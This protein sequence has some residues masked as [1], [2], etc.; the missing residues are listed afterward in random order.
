MIIMLA[1]LIVV[2]EVA[3]RRLRMRVEILDETVQKIAQ[4]VDVDL[5]KLKSEVEILNKT[6]KEPAF[7]EI[8]E[9][10]QFVK[11]KTEESRRA[12]EEYVE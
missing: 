12:G 11:R 9:F 7:N 8:A 3:R 5:S 10:I 6:I 1:E 2:D 4:N